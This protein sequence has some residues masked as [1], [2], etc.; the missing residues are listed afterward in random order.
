MVMSETFFVGAKALNGS[1]CHTMEGRIHKYVKDP[2][3]NVKLI[4][5]YGKEVQ[6]NET[7]VTGTKL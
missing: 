1:R 5:W 6:H 3:V 2:W 7:N 4:E